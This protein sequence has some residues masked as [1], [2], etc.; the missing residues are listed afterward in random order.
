MQADFPLPAESPLLSVRVLMYTYAL[1]S[2]ADEPQPKW[3]TR[4]AATPQLTDGEAVSRQYSR[5]NYLLRH[6]VLECEMSIRLEW[7]RAHQLQ[8]ALSLGGVIP[9]VARRR[10]PW[11][12]SSEFR[13]S[14]AARRDNTKGG[15]ISPA[16]VS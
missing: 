15:R 8:P 16:F 4:D 9:L 6:R 14:R 2:A 3:R 13:V 7:T 11:P 1:V 12:L 5:N 10:A